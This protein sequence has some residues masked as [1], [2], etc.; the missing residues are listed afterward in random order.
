MKVAE[1]R[2]GEPTLPIVA[3]LQAAGLLIL[4]PATTLPKDLRNS[5][6]LCEDSLLGQDISL[7]IGVGN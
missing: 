4:V 2:Q 3:N 5:L 1:S 6:L 7:L